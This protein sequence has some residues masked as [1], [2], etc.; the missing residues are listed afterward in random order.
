MRT[1]KDLRQNSMSTVNSVAIS[2]TCAIIRGGERSITVFK[3]FQIEIKRSF[4]FVGR[5]EWSI[6]GNF[7]MKNIW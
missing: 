1:S 7:A 3:L 6:N 4:N 5:V 2:E